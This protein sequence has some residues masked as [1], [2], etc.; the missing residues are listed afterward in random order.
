MTTGALPDPWFWF[1]FAV[2]ILWIGG[3]FA[4][5]ALRRIQAGEPLV[6]R[7]PDRADFYESMASGRNLGSFLFRIGGASRC[8]IVCVADG[9]L[10]TDLIFPFNLFMFLNFYGTRINVRIAEIRSIEHKSRFLV[11]D[12]VV[13]RWDGDHAYEFKLRNPTDFIQALDPTGRI[14]ARSAALS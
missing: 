4:F 2:P 10:G 11:G 13:V 14:R 3:I 1:F 6:P 5:G 9:R 7:R 8:L 12:V